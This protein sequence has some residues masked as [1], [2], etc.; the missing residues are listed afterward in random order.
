MGEAQG[1][2]D[3]CTWL[4]M[5]DDDLWR[6]SL[7]AR[8]CAGTVIEPTRTVEHACKLTCVDGRIWCSMDSHARRPRHMLPQQRTI[9]EVQCY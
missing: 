8:P 5:R 6:V 7:H 9:T 3:A 4:R 2:R 1:R